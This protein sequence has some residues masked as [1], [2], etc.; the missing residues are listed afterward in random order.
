MRGRKPAL[1]AIEGGLADLPKPPS[2][3]KGE[4]RAEWY[5][6]VP[7]L[8]ARR[9]LTDAMMTSVEAYCIAAGAVR[10]CQEILGREGH[11]IDGPRGIRRHPASQVQTQMLTEQRRW[12]AELG[13]TPASRGKVGAAP[14]GEDGDA[15]PYAS[16]GI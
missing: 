16:L 15:D 5:L 7:D 10:D 2:R 11:T 3:L 1:Q 13:L 6:V 14:A 9:V 8:I 4:A 12:A